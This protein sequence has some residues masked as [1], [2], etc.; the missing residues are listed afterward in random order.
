M[1]VS[2]PGKDNIAQLEELKRESTEELTN[3]NAD[4]SNDRI[5]IGPVWFITIQKK[6]S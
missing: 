1:S 6:Y 4:Q 3:Q 2:N 5:L